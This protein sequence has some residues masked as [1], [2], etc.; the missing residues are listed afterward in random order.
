MLNFLR[1]K[2]RTQIS[3]YIENNTSAHVCRSLN[4]LADTVGPA[5]RC[6]R[7]NRLL[8]SLYV[9]CRCCTANPPPGRPPAGAPHTPSGKR[10]DMSRNKANLPICGTRDNG[11]HNAWE[12]KQNRIVSNNCN[13]NWLFFSTLALK[14][15]T[16]SRKRYFA[17]FVYRLLTFVQTIIV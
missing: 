17:F 13:S 7:R 6:L 11:R 3:F 1:K 5:F 12:L 9:I 14:Y 15:S 8:R 16:I 4:Y 10:P 2:K